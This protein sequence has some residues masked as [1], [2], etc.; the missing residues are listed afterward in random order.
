MG[1]LMIPALPEAYVTLR[2][3]YLSPQCFRLSV[4]GSAQDSSP[5]ESR[6][7]GTVLTKLACHND[8]KHGNKIHSPCL[9]HRD[10]VV[11][12]LRQT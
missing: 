2:G 12:V 1:A 6:K 4:Y 9:L 11:A 3:L 8:V 5:P 7:V 10:H